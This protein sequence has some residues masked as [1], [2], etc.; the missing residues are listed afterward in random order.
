[1]G[2][3]EY[4]GIGS[5]GKSVAGIVDAESSKTARTKLRQSGI[6]PTEVLEGS[7]LGKR[8]GQSAPIGF[9][10]FGLGERVGLMDLSVATRQLATLLAA[11]LPLMEALTAL[12]DQIEHREL[13]T[14][15]ASIRERVREGSSLAAV[16]GLYPRVFSDV[17]VNMVNAG[18]SSGTLDAMLTR[19]ADYLES[20]VK[21]RNQIRAAFAYPILMLVVGVGTLFLLLTYVVP[22]VTKIFEE[23]HQTLPLSTIILI[24]TSKFL[25]QYWWLVVLVVLAAAVGF[26]R[27]TATK[28]GRVRLERL[29]LRLP[30]L[31]RV[32]LLVAVSRFTRTLSTLLSSGVPLL[33]ALDVVKKVVHLGPISD[34]IDRARESV[35]EGQ[36][37]A[38]PLRKSGMFPALVTHMIAI[39]E[40]SGDLEPMLVKVSEAF[41]NEV[42]TTIVTM[43]SLLTPVMI[44]V[45]G[46]IVLFIVASILL[47]IF[48]LSQVVS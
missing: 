2:V 30:V 26:Q 9:R 14:V 42:Q 33:T 29:L 39:G 27:Y 48:E 44:L 15:V 20:Q 25:S 13:K 5:D 34:A 24:K 46:V 8:T 7:D 3:F 16:L 11:N 21:L 1:M 18:E 35:R 23:M 37:L 36:S 41:D 47:P 22:K 17:Y 40:K 4:R 45:M 38:D 43:T 12:G 19:L 31:G 28:E 6:F 10:R 32:V